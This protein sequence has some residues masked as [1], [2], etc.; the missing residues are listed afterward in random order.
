MQ[1]KLVSL[2]LTF[3]VAGVASAIAGGHAVVSDEQLMENLKGSAP[4]AILENATIMNMG[5]DGK[6]KVIKEGTNGWTCLDPGGEPMCADGAAMKWMGAY[7]EKKTPPKELG[8]VY[9]M[10]G[11]Q[12]VSNTDPYA[13]KETPDNNWIKTGPHVMILGD[14][15]EMAKTYPNT[16]KADPTKPYVMWPNTPYQHLMLPLD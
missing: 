14:I 11:D 15:G 7:M 10:K 3:L 8:F 1:P 9:M 13:K 4:A 16:P 12:G 6:M 2:A 5:A